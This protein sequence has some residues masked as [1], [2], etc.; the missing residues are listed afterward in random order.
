MGLDQNSSKNQFNSKIPKHGGNIHQE[1]YKLGGNI[2][3]FVD[4]S[5]S[6]VPF[7]PP[8]KLQKHL[9]Q[10]LKSPDLTSYPD[11]SHFTLRKAIG[12]W[13]KV[14][15]DMVF[16]GNGAAEINT[17]SAKDASL[18][19]LSCLPSPGFAD[20]ERALK[21]WQGDF[22]HIPLKLTWDFVSPQ[23]FP[24]TS[25]AQVIWVTNPHNPTGQLWSRESLEPLL[26][27][28]N[29]VICDEAFL[30]LVL[31]GEKESLI[32]LTEKYKNLIVIRS[33]TKLFAL[34]GL[35]IG[36]AISSKERLQRW[37]KWRDPW[38]LNGLAIA[39]GIII[40]NDRTI[41]MHQINKVQAWINQEGPWLH[42]RLKSLPG[43]TSHPSS[44]NFQLIESKQSLLDLHD[45]LAKRKILVRDCRSF[46]SLGANWLRIS[47]R[48]RSENQKIFQS[49][50]E[51]LK[52]ID[53]EY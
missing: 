45:Q 36:Y 51:I 5:A 14:D 1:V 20:Y 3:D 30:P 29:L 31:N 52:S 26:A 53:V 25:N 28:H 18:M 35:R 40:M 23:A 34:A 7:P 19:G 33:L 2:N 4:A 6:L 47:L 12:N 9:I 39:A 49:I 38:P 15:P 46:A 43:I 16:P 8:E 21:C 17:W 10:A 27:K 22:E 24:I 13:H 48:Q 11:R 32:P 44:T 50:K 41:M 42:S 37:Y